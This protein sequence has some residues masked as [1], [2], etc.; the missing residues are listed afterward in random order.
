[1]TQE[2]LILALRVRKLFSKIYVNL[3][4][5]NSCQVVYKK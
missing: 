1:M 5:P 4:N 3:G 2:Y